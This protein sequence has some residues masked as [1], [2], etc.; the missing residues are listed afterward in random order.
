V[1]LSVEP[2]VE[3]A[4]TMIPTVDVGAMA[5][6]AAVNCQLLWIAARFVSR[7]K[8]PAVFK[9]PVPVKS[10][11]VSEFMFMPDDPNVTRPPNSDVDDAWKTSVTLSVPL[12]VDDAC[13]MRP[14]VIVRFP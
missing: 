10:V 2:I 7:V 4:L 9:S 5:S 13:E 3:L 11:N 14:P 8:T 6:P 1:T 12:K